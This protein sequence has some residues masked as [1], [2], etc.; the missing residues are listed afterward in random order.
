MRIEYVSVIRRRFW[1]LEFWSFDLSVQRRRDIFLHG[2][3][4]GKVRMKSHDGT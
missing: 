4:V 1:I 3:V 2:G